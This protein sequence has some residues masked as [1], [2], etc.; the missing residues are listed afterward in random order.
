MLLVFSDLDGTI[1]DSETYSPAEAR[2][3]LLLL[4]RENITLVPASSKTFDEM[5]LVVH[6][7]G[8]RGPFIFENGGGIAY[9]Q[10][11]GFYIHA[12]GPGLQDLSD[13]FGI[14]LSLMEKP[15]RLVRDMDLSEIMERTGFDIEKAQKVLL[16]RFTL[17]FVPEGPPLNHDQI[18]T[19]NQHLEKWGFHVTRGERFH[20]FTSLYSS[21]GEAMVELIRYYHE[22]KGIEKISSVAIGDSINDISMLNLSDMAYVVRQKDGSSIRVNNEHVYVTKAPGP[23]GFTEAIKD[24]LSREMQD[25]CSG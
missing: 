21:K 13:G 16:R 25:G 24:L 15:P 3:G 1:L 5:C 19:W 20:Y 4:Q 2:P 17:P 18:V 11:D 22:E 14:L 7:I 23:A 10:D 6:D 12:M 9:P 8:C